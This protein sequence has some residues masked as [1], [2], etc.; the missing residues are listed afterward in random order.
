MGKSSFEVLQAKTS[1]QRDSFANA[2]DAEKSSLRK[3]TSLC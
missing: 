1:N 2:I 3:R